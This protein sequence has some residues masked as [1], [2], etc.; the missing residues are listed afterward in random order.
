MKQS[1]IIFLT[2]FLLSFT[3]AAADTPAP[4]Y[5]VYY[6]A[7]KAAA[8]CR[9]AGDLDCMVQNLLRAEQAALD[10]DATRP[11]QDDNNW[12]EFADWQ[13][14]NA[15]YYL[16]LAQAKGDT[17]DKLIL[18]EALY[19]LDGKREY[20]VAGKV[21]YTISPAVTQK[22]EGL[23]Q[24]SIETPAVLEKIKSNIAYCKA[25]LGIKD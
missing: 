23:S 22:H 9:T 6:E 11:A 2:L 24:R 19:L 25:Q 3:L 14:N 12:V 1:I 7:K 20:K 16:I 15:A 17:R 8:D 5:E 4:A 21:I 10:W 18:E 13:R